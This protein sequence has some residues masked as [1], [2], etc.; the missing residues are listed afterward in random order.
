MSP[1]QPPASRVTPAR[2]PKLPLGERVVGGAAKATIEL[3]LATLRKHTIVLAGAGSGKTTLLER[4]VQEAALLGVPSIIVDVGGELSLLGAPWPSAPDGWRAG[5]ADKARSYHE[6]SEVVIWTPG[7][8]ANPLSFNPIP[9][10]AAVADDAD[11]LIAALGMVVSSLAPIVVSNAGRGGQ[12]AL[13][14]LMGAGQHF[15]RI[16]GGNLSD[17]IQL[18]RDLPPE[19][20]EGFDRGDQTA[21]KMSELLL[22]ESRINPLLAEG[23]PI[24]DPESL[25]SASQPGKT[26]VSV[27]NLGGLQGEALRQQFVGQLSMA[28][29]SFVKKHPAKDR[30]LLG[31]LVID[32]A[33]D[34]APSGKAVPGKDN[35]MRLVAQARK[36]GLGMLF[37]TQ[38]PK[39]IDPQLIASCATQFCGRTSAPAGIQTVQEQQRQRGGSGGDVA[40]HSPGVFYA[41]SEGMPA[42]VRIATRA[43]L[44]A[45]PSSP[46]D[47]AAIIK[48]AEQSRRRVRVARD[49][50]A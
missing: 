34:F 2:E 35:L 25:L 15:A 12:A 3:P 41:H 50:V 47:E 30:P 42:P 38:A 48:R 45:H 26:R 46:P 1:A 7:I 39:G 9:D 16:G 20:Y 37:A 17:L 36:Y 40:T 31:L 13:G 43:S 18:L 44:S 32:E 4:I 10:L 33:R 23:A 49:N 6:Q 11:E 27:I 14:V 24:V 8:R 19:A 29:F 5:D 21:R 22:A 28:L